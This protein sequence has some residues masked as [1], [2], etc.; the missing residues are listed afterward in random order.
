MNSRNSKFRS[1]LSFDMRAPEFGASPAELYDAA[2]DM[3]A[4]GDEL[5]IDAVI[6]PEHH[7]SEDGYNPAPALM[8][9]AA[10]AR[11]QRMEMVLGAIVLPL[12]DP[13]EVAETIAVTDLIC[14]G[15]LTTTLA[16]GYVQAEFD[17]FGRSLGDRGR[18]MDEGIEVITRALAGERFMYGEREV[19]VRPRPQTRPPK[20]LV[21]G[22]VPAAVRRA[23][24]Y[25]LGLWTLQH[26]MMSDC[27]KLIELYKE[28]CKKYG[29]EPGPIWWTTPA[30]HVTHDPD[31]AW[32]EIGPHVLHLVKSYASWASDVDTTT[33]PF[34]GMDSVEAIRASGMINVLTPA[35]TLEFAS[36]TP[37]SLTPL[38]SGLSPKVGWRM[39][40]LFAAEVFPH[41][42]EA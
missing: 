13:V 28:E 27:Q 1:V 19:F 42:R 7:A 25:G 32:E 2:L 36:K 9:A 6:F 14:Q 4:F 38:I 24:R 31:A 16:A 5:G 23:A 37:I 41:L 35:Q 20:I 18:L 12:H 29:R 33:S 11:T 22:G 21:G 30:V 3:I 8:A 15:R 10:A 39:L 17:M 26:P 40:E 34:Y